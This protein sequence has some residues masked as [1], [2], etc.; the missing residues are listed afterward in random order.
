MKWQFFLNPP[1]AWDAMLTDCE[2]AVSAID[3]EQYIFALDAIGK[4]FLDVLRRKAKE[5][6]Q[7]RLLLDMAGSYGFYNS[8]EVKKLRE[9]KI[10]VQFFNPISP[11]RMYNFSSW[12]LRDHRKILVIDDAVGYT[13]GVGIDGRMAHWRDTHARVEGVVVRE[14]QYAFDRMWEITKR[15]KRFV[16]FKK[17]VLTDHEFRFF[18]NSPGFRQRFVYRNILKAIRSAKRYAYFTTPYFIPNVRLFQ[19]LLSA[20]RRRV[21]VRILLPQKSDVRTT[22]I[23]AGS[24][25]TLAL[26]QGIKIYRYKNSVL[27]A[28]TGVVDD[29]WATTGSANLDNISLLLNHEGNIISE[30]QEFAAEIKRQFLA[31]IQT[32][33][34]LNYHAWIRRPF[35][36]K[37]LEVLSWPIHGFL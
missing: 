23:A 28:K 7:V 37:V 33:D 10:D 19:A 5:G 3:F 35:S 16:R 6:I 2:R 13:G 25:F 9:E 24:Y 20:A 34:E 22:D 8:P 18:T 1:D 17:S 30:K 32:S 12:F 11:W 15:G 31:D 27:H 14:M 4:K 29:R 26:K 21:D 36:L